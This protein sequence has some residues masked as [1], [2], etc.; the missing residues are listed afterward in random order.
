MARYTGP[1]RRIVRRLGTVLSGLTRK[2]PEDRPYPPGQHGPTRVGRRSRVSEYGVRLSEKQKLRY[3]YGL[4]EVQLRNYVRRASGATG[5]TG[6]LLLETLERRLDNVVFRLGL[7][8][9]IPAA[10]QL[11]VH[12]HVLLNG[13]RTTVPGL[14]VSAG[15]VIAMAER[16]RGHPLVREGVKRGPELA[17]PSYLERA[18]DGLGGRVTGDPQRQDVPIDL[19]ESLVIEFYAR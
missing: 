2:T 16:S 15:D 18:P 14:E 4:S 1:R 12:G 6:E 9:T 10:R 3:Y 8:P 11:V 19:R 5:P 13:R 17:L 7:A